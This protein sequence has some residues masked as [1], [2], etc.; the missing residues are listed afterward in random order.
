MIAQQVKRHYESG[1]MKKPGSALTIVK[2]NPVGANAI[3]LEIAAQSLITIGGVSGKHVQKV[4]LALA[5]NSPAACVRQ[6]IAPAKD[7]A[8][9]GT[10]AGTAPTTY[11][12]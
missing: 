1:E 12:H 8:V 9:V 10:L 6:A 5:T 3:V 7:V 11:R 2:L 4:E